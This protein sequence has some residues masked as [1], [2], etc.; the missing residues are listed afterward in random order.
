[1]GSSTKLIIG[2]GFAAVM[3]GGYFA[4]SAFMGAEIGQP[5]D[6]EFGCKGLDGVCLEGG[7]TMCS[8]HCESADECPSGYSCDHVKVLNIDGK[9]GEVDESSAPVCLP[10]ASE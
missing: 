9:T 4:M 1:M 2:F 5:C 7:D 8:R 10:G 6:K 3:I